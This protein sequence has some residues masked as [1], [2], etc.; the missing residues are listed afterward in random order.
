MTTTL[1]PTGPLQQTRDG[2]TSRS[3]EICVNSRPVGAIGLATD[4]AFGHTAGIL[5]GLR[6]DEPD[7]RRG[8]ATVAVLAAEE[9]LR[10]WG[11]E[12]V[13]ASVPPDATAALSLLDSLGY[14]ERSRNMDKE[15]PSA[16]PALPAG[17][18]ARPMTGAEYDVWL[19][20]AVDSF[21][22]IWIDRGTEP[23]AARA[24]SELSHRQN[25]PEGLAT[26]DT[27]FHVLLHEGSAVGHVWTG[28]REIRP[29]EWA[30]YVYDVEVAENRRGRGFGRALMLVAERVA[31]ES[32][33][34]L[35]GL[36]VFADNTPAV[37]LYES[38][39]YRTTSRNFAKRLL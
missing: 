37:R 33:S 30:A 5:D 28:R 26:P 24:K 11:C 22:Q 23:A 17:V 10:G 12:Q 18:E 3:Y 8:R 6:V 20:A 9:V 7:R 21:A 32:G 15:P 35:L 19:A 34:A 2:G 13:M 14:T 36:H 27:A 29:G 16:P 38:L 1:R 4:A 31:L 25:L 39:G